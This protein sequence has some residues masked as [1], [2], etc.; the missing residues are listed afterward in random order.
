M[1]FE[2]YLRD[3]SGAV[4][5]CDEMIFPKSVEELCQAV[6]DATTIQGARTGLAGGAVPQGGKVINLSGLDKI[7][8]V[9]QR[10]GTTYLRVQAG[11]TLAAIQTAAQQHGCFF[12][13]NP[14]EKTATIGGVFVCNAIG[15]SSVRYGDTTKY[16]TAVSVVTPQGE[17]KEF[18]QDELPNKPDGVVAEL[19]LLLLPLPR[20]TWGV[21][22]FFDTHEQLLNFVPTLLDATLD[23]AEYIGCLPLLQQLRTHHTNL[24][25]ALPPIPAG[26]ACAVYI[27]LSGNDGD[28][29]EEALLNQLEQFLAVGGAE[30][31]TWA[32]N[33]PAEVNRL[34][35]M[36]HALPELVG[37]KTLPGKL[38]LETDLEAPP[39]KLAEYLAR[40]HDG[41]DLA[42]GN[43]LVYGHLLSN[44]LHVAFFAQD[45]ED[46]RTASGQIERWKQCVEADGGTVHR[47]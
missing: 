12:P 31:D 7:L 5:Y 33:M 15:A 11:V 36:R 21:M 38:R 29:L 40:Y 41:L 42:K 30:E 46:Y 35:D 10:D 6:P 9:E 47:R 45:D 25:R 4:G 32:M 17:R 22:Y 27:E 8:G 26:K 23:A 44:R 16:V 14:T 19:E 43:G 2:S 37:T 34:R 18:H 24:F 3:E 1:A 28:L 39:E 13:P 20:E